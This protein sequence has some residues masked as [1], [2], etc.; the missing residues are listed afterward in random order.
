MLNCKYLIIAALLLIL[1]ELSAKE[2]PQQKVAI[3]P[4]ITLD[5]IGGYRLSASS[6]GTSRVAYSAGPIAIS[7]ND[8]HLYIAGHSKHFS[9]ASFYLPDVTL[10]KDTN[11]F[12]IA[13]PIS[14]FVKIAPERSLSNTADRITGIEVLGDELL[15][16]TDEYYDANKDNLEHLV[17]FS[18]RYNLETSKQSGFFT[19]EG[20]SHTAGWMSK[21]PSPLAT[22]IN[23][24]YLAG[25]ASNLPINGRL[26]IGPTLFTWFPYYLSSYSGPTT[27]STIP[28]I[29]YSLASPLH[30]D[31]YNETGENKIWTEVSEAVYGFFL[32][33]Q[34]YYLVLGSSG[35]HKSKMGYKIVQNNGRT[36]AGPCAYDHTD[37]HNFFWLFETAQIKQ[38]VQSNIKPSEIK[39]IKYGNL[40]IYDYRHKII[41]ADFNY[42]SERLYLLVDKVDD[43]QT[44]FESLP[45]ILVYKIKETSL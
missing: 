18:N 17:V 30:K 3:G 43:T 40:D 25:S 4:Q 6:I 27:I 16:T 31:S 38:A 32:P 44:R 2:L 13:K 19:L 8:R 35:G 1:F 5:L 22:E 14:P 20:K 15:V 21:V 41:G 28:I 26:S 24:L 36:C 39:P 29:D 12:P 33:Q 11:F 9:L 7:Q 23:A 10:S 45:I 34:N 42:D 37:Y